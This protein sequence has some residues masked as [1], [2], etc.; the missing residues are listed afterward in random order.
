[1]PIHIIQTGSDGNGM[2]FLPSNKINLE[3]MAVVFS[4]IKNHMVK[5]IA[6]VQKLTDRWKSKSL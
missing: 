5:M 4:K 2:S 3:S 6:L 1:M